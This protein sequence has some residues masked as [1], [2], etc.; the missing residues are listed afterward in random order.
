VDKEACGPNACSALGSQIEPDHAVV[1]AVLCGLV[2]EK[3]IQNQYTRAHLVKG[4]FAAKRILVHGKNALLH[5]EL[6][7]DLHHTHEHRSPGSAS[8][9][10]L[11]K[12]QGRG[13]LLNAKLGACLVDHLRRR[14]VCVQKMRKD[15]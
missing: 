10:H 12:A 2:S 14:R 9:A 1:Q 7:L 11:L 13:K 8:T 3:C 4:Q 6:E 5:T 15:A